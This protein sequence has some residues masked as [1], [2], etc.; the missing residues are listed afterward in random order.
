MTRMDKVFA[1]D[2]ATRLNFD[3]MLAVYRSGYTRIPVYDTHPQNIIGIL[4]TKDLI[5][6][7]PD[8]EVEVRAIVALQG[9]APVQFILDVTPLNEVFKLFKTCGTHLM[10]ACR[11][12]PGAGGAGGETPRGG[13]LPATPF[14]DAAGAATTTR[15]AQS[16]L[17]IAPKEVTGVITLE[18]VLEEVI[19]DEIVD[20]SDTF[21]SNE[22][23]APRVARG[24]GCAWGGGG[25]GLVPFRAAAADT[26]SL[27][28]SPP[29]QPPGLPPRHRHLPL[30]L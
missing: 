21:T 19:Q 1:L 13:A 28:P 3:N 20:E 7:D 2:A 5:L 16:A 11:L 9:D 4:Y 26:P 15:S 23:G 29:P 24:G 30:P 14:A 17:A 18:D 8:D 10:V 12:R 27:L 22:P 25:V 6:I